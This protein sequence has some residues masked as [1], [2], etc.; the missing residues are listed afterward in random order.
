MYTL[1]LGVFMYKYSIDDLPSSF[2]GYFTKRCDIHSYQTRHKN[3]F[4][5]TKNR[6]TFCD[7]AIR[8]S[9]PILWNS[10]DKEFKTSKSVKHFRKQFKQQMISKYDS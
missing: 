5:L 10:L 1:E 7:H 3:D 2:N 6:K 4:N 9:G 8:T